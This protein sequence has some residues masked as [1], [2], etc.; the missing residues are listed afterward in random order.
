MR[1]ICQDMISGCQMQSFS[2]IPALCARIRDADSGAIVDWDTFED[3]CTFRRLFVCPSATR[4]ILR[5]CQKMVALDAC[6]TKNKKYPTQLFLA[7]VHDGNSQIVP[8]AYGLAPVENFENWMWFLHNL[9][10]SIQ[11]LSSDEVFIVSDRQKGLE[12]AVSEMLPENPH[13][14]CGHHLK[15]NVQKHFGKVAVQVLQNLFH[16]PYE[17]RFN[18][19]LEEA[20]NRLDFGRKFVQYVRRIDPERY[21]RYALPLPRYGRTTITEF[22]FRLDAIHAW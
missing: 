11:D 21:V 14:H 10:I 16:A 5:F 9:K 7:T 18:S 15:M 13:M 22:V 12:K 20:G 8:L 1:D 3:S 6:F 17:E 4:P 2:H 19:I